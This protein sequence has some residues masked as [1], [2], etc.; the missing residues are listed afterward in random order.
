M[1]ACQQ[2]LS[3]Y[4]DAFSRELTKGDMS[5]AELKSRLCKRSCKETKFPKIDDF[6]DEKFKKR[7]GRDY[8]IQDKYPNALQGLDLTKMTEGDM[9]AWATKNMQGELLEQER[10]REKIARGEISESELK[11]RQ[12]ERQK[13]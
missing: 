9:E 12:E 8:Y 2:A 6:V 3:G 11:R 4:E 5:L 7:D 1:G 13:E 10:L